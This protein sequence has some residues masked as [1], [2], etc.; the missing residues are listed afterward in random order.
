MAKKSAKTRK[1]TTLSNRIWSLVEKNG[2][3][4][5]RGHSAEIE[6]ALSKYYGDKK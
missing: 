1:N 6:Y 3:P 4:E 5:E 2:S